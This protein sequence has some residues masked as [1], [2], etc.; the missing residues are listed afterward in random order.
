MLSIYI[1]AFNQVNRESMMFLGA[2]GNKDD[3][4]ISLHFVVL[5]N[6]VL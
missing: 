6:Y 5:L 3:S 1:T 2:H 4:K